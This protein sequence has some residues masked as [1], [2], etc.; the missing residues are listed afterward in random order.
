M[1]DALSPLRH[2]QQELEGCWHPRL[3]GIVSSRRLP[4]IFCAL[5]NSGG[6]DSGDCPL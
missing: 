3:I 1:E 5:S 6:R 4:S 2:W